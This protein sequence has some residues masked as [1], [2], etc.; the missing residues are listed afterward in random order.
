MD[1]DQQRGGFARSSSEGS[2]ARPPRSRPARGAGASSGGAAARAAWPRS[3]ARRATS[4]SSS[5]SARVCGPARRLAF[6]PVPIYE[7]RCPNGHT[8]ELFQNMTDRRPS[9]LLDVRRRAGREDPLPGR[10]PL[11]GL[12]LLLD[13]LRAREGGRA[14]RTADKPAEGE[15]EKKPTDEAEPQPRLAR[16]S[17]ARR[18]RRAALA[19]AS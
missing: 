8:F 15:P 6:R 18:S 1:G 3:R 14:R 17:R 19:A 12:G 10:R 2:S 7:Y 11:Q 16:A 13:G 9:A 5:G 4:S